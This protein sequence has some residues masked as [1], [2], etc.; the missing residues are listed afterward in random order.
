MVYCTKCGTQN[1]DEADIC[2]KCGTSLRIS[3]T[4]NRNWEDRLERGAEELGERAERFGRSM[5]NECFGLP[6]GNSIIG[7][8]FG[9][10]IILFGVRDL[11]DWNIDLGPYIIIIVGVL[12]AAGALYSRNKTKRY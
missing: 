2:V 5:E 10:I 1:E 7:I 12:I 3:H 8:I 11:Y 9:L 4:E 6:Q